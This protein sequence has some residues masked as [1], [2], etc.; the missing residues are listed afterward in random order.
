MP[1]RKP[2]LLS[3]ALYV[4]VAAFLAYKRVRKPKYQL[5]AEFRD[6]G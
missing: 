4:A 1:T 2:L 3:L 5:P 6:Q